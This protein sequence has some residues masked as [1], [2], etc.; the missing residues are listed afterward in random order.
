MTYKFRVL[1]VTV[2]VALWVISVSANGVSWTKAYQNED[3]PRGSKGGTIN[4]SHPE[5]TEFSYLLLITH[6]T[7]FSDEQ[8]RAHGVRT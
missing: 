1:S 3:C 5:S 8:K 6:S 7:C 4:S 2:L